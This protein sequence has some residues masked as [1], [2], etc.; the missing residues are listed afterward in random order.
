MDGHLFEFSVHGSAGQ[1]LRGFHRDEPGMGVEGNVEGVSSHLLEGKE[2]VVVVGHR[3]FWEVG[4][5]DVI[6]CGD[7]D[8]ILF[9]VMKSLYLE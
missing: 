4:D 1:R 8:V 6:Y 9:G 7:D 2:F 5:D 3:S